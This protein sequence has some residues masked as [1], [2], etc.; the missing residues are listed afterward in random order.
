EINAFALPGGFV[1]ITRSLLEF[2]Q[3]NQDELAFILGHEMAHIIQGHVMDRLLANS[4]IRASLARLTPVGGLLGQPI[5]GLAATL[6]NQGYSRDNELEADRVGIQLA[7]HAGFDP[8][9]V[10]RLFTRMRNLGG[11]RLPLGG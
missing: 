11:D 6:L 10:T 4:M 5:A 2:C 9:A 7:G 3:W 8:T 1:F